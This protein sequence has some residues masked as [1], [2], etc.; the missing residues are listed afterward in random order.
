MALQDET[1]AIQYMNDHDD[2][3]TIGDENEDM[4]GALQTRRKQREEELI[5]SQPGPSGEQSEW[6]S[7]QEP[8]Q[9]RP[10]LP[11]SLPALR[12]EQGEILRPVS[13]V[14]KRLLDGAGSKLNASI[15]EKLKAKVKGLQAKAVLSEGKPERKLR[16]LRE[17][18]IPD[19]FE[20]A[21]VFSSFVYCYEKTIDFTN[22]NEFLV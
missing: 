15:R 12:D 1:T 4:I 8:T 2:I 6:A 17:L 18:P 22:N 13:P 5:E 16:G 14:S 7:T 20:E 11:R 9:S 10:P 3:E 19:R 21:E